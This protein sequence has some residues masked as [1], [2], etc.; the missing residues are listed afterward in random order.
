M[1]D[2]GEDGENEDEVKPEMNTRQMRKKKRGRN[3]TRGLQCPRVR[4]SSPPLYLSGRHPPPGNNYHA[5]FD[6]YKLEEK[7]LRIARGT[8]EGPLGYKTPAVLIYFYESLTLNNI[9]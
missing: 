5:K 3:R 4:I 1:R 8:Y 2:I 7:I 6:H 9:A